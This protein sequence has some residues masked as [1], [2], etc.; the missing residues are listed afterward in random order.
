MVHRANRILVAGANLKATDPASL[1]IDRVDRALGSHVDRQVKVDLVQPAAIG[2]GR[3]VSHSHGSRAKDIVQIRTSSV[4][5]VQQV[6]LGFPGSG[7]KRLDI[8]LVVV[9]AYVWQ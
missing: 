4:S 7:T 2:V 6:L 1:R 9:N 8:D 5:R 3:E